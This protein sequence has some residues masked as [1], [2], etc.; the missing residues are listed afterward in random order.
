VEAAAERRARI[1]AERAGDVVKDV[2]A[3][4]RSGGGERQPGGAA[5]EASAAVAAVAAAAASQGA[6]VATSKGGLENANKT[7][8]APTNGALSDRRNILGRNK[9]I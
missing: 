8:A 7:P 2:A 1:A 9:Q 5:A 3:V 4:S 6:A